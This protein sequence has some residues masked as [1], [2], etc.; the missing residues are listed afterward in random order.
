[1]FAAG[2]FDQNP[3]VDINNDNYDLKDSRFFKDTLL[4]GH[5]IVLDYMPGFGRLEDELYKDLKE[6][7]KK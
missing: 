2:A 5:E 4:D 6:A 7:M 3:A 1:M